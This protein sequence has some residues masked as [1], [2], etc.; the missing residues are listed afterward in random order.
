M[1][2]GQPSIAEAH[3]LHALDDAEVGQ[4][5]R[6]E[7]V[8]LLAETARP[9]DADVMTPGLDDTP[10][11]RL[12]RQWL[13]VQEGTVTAAALEDLRGQLS[14]DDVFAHRLYH[15]I[16][17]KTVGMHGG[18]P[19]FEYIDWL[20]ERI[21]R[22]P[23]LVLEL[24]E[25]RTVALEIALALQANPS[26]PSVVGKFAEQVIAEALLLPHGHPLQLRGLVAA[27]LAIDQ[28][29]TLILVEHA[30]R[31]ADALDPLLRTR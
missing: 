28:H 21:E 9:A 6:R 7:L 25:G 31:Y 10:P 2:L 29:L 5:A 15:G 4:A 26:M 13:Q 23:D 20:H 19:L 18:F 1:D 12:V 14:D 3:Y 16:R 8:V 30:S 24:I 11:S 22:Q 27:G 17:T